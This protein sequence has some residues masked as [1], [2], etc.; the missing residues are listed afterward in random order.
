M[1]VL[2]QGDTPPPDCYRGTE[3]IYSAPIVTLLPSSDFPEHEHKT[4]V[5]KVRCNPPP[6]SGPPESGP[7]AFFFLTI[8][9][10]SFIHYTVLFCSALSCSVLFCP[11][12]PRVIP[13]QFY[14]RC[15]VSLCI[16]SFISK[17]RENKNLGIKNHPG[18]LEA[19]LTS[20]GHHHYLMAQRGRH[21]PQF[22]HM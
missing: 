16:C 22:S 1:A 17:T 21:T 18:A 2:R 11:I 12:L 5:L 9:L 10:T 13:R 3:R 6:Q 20:Q 4:V 19:P 8:S 7:S 14:S 15:D